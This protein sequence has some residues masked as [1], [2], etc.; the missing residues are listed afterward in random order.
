MMSGFFQTPNK[1]IVKGYSLFS[2]LYQENI[3][4][5]EK[6]SRF[7]MVFGT[8]RFAFFRVRFNM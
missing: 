8:V 1:S 6:G 7:G 2:V 5:P 4:D 3:T